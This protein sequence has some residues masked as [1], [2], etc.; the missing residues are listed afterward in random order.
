MAVDHYENFPVASLLLPRRLR[1]PVRNIYRHDRSADDIADERTA[2]PGQRLEQLA[3]YRPALPHIDDG[4]M[5]LD[6]TGTISQLFESLEQDR[7]SVG[8][9]ESVTSGGELS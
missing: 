2:L 6:L 1:A 3:H 5:H 7:Q 8:E 9:G 4:S